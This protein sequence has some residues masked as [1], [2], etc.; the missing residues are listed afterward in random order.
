MYGISHI[1]NIFSGKVSLSI[2]SF[3]LFFSIPFGT[4]KFLLPLEGRTITS[5]TDGVFLFLNDIWLFVA[6]IVFFLFLKK[7][8]D[9]YVFFKKRGSGVFLGAFA[10]IALLSVFLSSHFLFS[11]YFF[12]RILFGF[13]MGFFVYTIVKHSGFLHAAWGMF[14]AGIFQ[15]I[16]GVAQFMTGKSV[17]ARYLGEIV[18]NES[19]EHIARVSIDGAFFLRA[20]GTMQHANILAAFLVLA[21]LTG[22]FLLFVSFEKK[23]KNLPLL[24]LV[25]AGLFLVSLGVAATFSRSGWVVFLVSLSVFLCAAF[26]FSNMRKNAVKIL[27]ILFLVCVGIFSVFGWAILP[28]ASFEKNEPS[29]NLRAAYMRVGESIIIKNPLLGV[30]IGNQVEY[31]KKNGLYERFDVSRASDFQPV[32]NIFLLALSE[33]GLLGGIPLGLFFVYLFI[34]FLKH[35]KKNSASL[36]LFSSL[37]GFFVFGLFDH[38]FWTMQSGIALFWIVTFLFILS[39]EGGRVETKPS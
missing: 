28:R 4:K 5:E 17:G 15:S 10:V 30:G 32:H 33:V 16:L 11:A 13:C 26:V 9:V 19:T 37:V 25:V 34:F 31:A 35:G 7:K 22:V 24:S 27:A 38:F 29:V 1:K 14:A 3:L 21:F 39:M 8:D 12:L 6:A 18:V 20:Y 23:E 2:L 36:W